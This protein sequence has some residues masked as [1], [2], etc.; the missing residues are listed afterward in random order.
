VPTSSR[1]RSPAAAPASRVLSTVLLLLALAG[2]A[3]AV[4]LWVLWHHA[5]G[6]GGAA[7]CDISD[8]LSCSKV[9]LSPFSAV[10][11]VPVAAWGA[12]AYLLAACLAAWA[13]ARRPHRAFPGGL[14]LVLAGA[15]TAAAAALAYVSEVLIRAF[16]V[17]CAASWATSLA[18]LAVALV[19][20]RRG[21]GPGAA[22]RADLAAVR[23]RRGPAAALAGAFAVAAVALLALYAAAP[24]RAAPAP[25]QRIPVG[26]PGS[27]PVYEFSDYLCP[28]CAVL[29]AHEPAIVAQ[30]PDVRFIRRFFPLDASCNP[31]IKQ[32][33]PGHESACELARGGICAER[34]GRFEAYDDAAFAGQGVRP[35]AEALA[36][37]VGLDLALFR[38]CMAAP[39]TEQR[40]AADVALGNQ[41]ALRGTPTLQIQGK[42]HGVD[43]LPALLG[44]KPV[45]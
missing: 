37:Q 40:L 23:A 13:L 5:H 30:R 22:L 45:R 21:G 33:V 38:D 10:L 16:C 42:L 14:L 27:L 11:G 25:Q 2:L 17:V 1:P 3:V 18:L 36:T 15:M 44:V 29:H 39:E 31:G 28:H 9:A 43:D 35:S 12:L 32:T 20:V 26:A 8:R 41:A 4:D 7:F 6:G 34:Q 24:W 19:L